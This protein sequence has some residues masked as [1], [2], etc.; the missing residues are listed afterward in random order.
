MGFLR[1]SLPKPGNTLHFL[2]VP[3]LRVVG[4]LKVSMTRQHARHKGSFCGIEGARGF[5]TYREA[6]EA[7]RFLLSRVQLSL[8]SENVTLTVQ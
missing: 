1:P 6:V 7:S 3:S 2:E 4:L 5:A 8:S